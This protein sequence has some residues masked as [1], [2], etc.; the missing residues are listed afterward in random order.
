MEPVLEL[1]GFN[2]LVRGRYGY[3]LANENDIYVGRSLIKYG[4][5]SQDEADLFQQICRPGD[6]VVEVGA[7]IGALTVPIARLVG[8]GGRV[9][10]CEPQPVIFQM[11][12]ANLALNSLINVDCYNCGLAATAGEIRIPQ[13][14]YRKPGNF[15]G[16]SLTDARTGTPI[17]LATVDALFRYDRLR[18]FKID[19]EGMEL[20]VLHG[21]VGIIAR[22]RPF[23]YVENDRLERSETLIRLI[24]SLGYRLWWHC[25]PLFNPHNFRGD[26]ENVFVDMVSANM[27]C[28]PAEIKAT[29][30]GQ[31]VTDPTL[32]PFRK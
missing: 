11:L 24:M 14:D 1:P 25:P 7:N 31:E 6:V 16:V 8:P 19:V 22:C 23:L 4:E 20:E 26:T 3:F 17:P 13:Y 21:A 29:V 28:I 5:Y 18:L 30:P 15:G 32:H 2:K 9:V 10:A 27:L 12:C